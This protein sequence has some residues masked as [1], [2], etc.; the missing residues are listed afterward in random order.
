[1][2]LLIACERG[3]WSVGAVVLVPQ[4]MSFLHPN[5]HTH[6][7]CILTAKVLSLPQPPFEG[8]VK[9]TD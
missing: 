8:Q 9:L 7:H 5:T 1:M 2:S 4:L 3:I 6:T